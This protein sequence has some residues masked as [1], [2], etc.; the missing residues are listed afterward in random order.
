MLTTRLL[1]R[2]AR[3]LRGGFTLVELLV[4]IGI[5]AILAG[6]ALGPITNGIKKAK[7][8]SGL[9]TA[10]AIGLAMYSCANDNQQVY[11]DNGT[12]GVPVGNTGAG[13]MAAVSPLLA[14]G[15][16]TDPSIFFISGGTASKFSGTAASAA[17]GMAAANVSW[18]FMGNGGAGASATNYQYVPLLWSS[19]NGGGGSEPSNV[20]GIGTAGVAMYATPG[21][22]NPFGTAGMA[23]FYMNNS[24]TFVTS[25]LQGTT[26]E[27]LMLSTTSNSGGASTAL[28]VNKGGG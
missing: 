3:F 11:P 24:A 28:S 19:V 22:S 1:R 16:V 23:I 13:A 5:I 9:Q 10:H 14:G 7:Q 18:D 21:A 2:T 15:Y 17:S 27:V 26:P 12:P 8:S 6:V 25:S 20:T 4:V